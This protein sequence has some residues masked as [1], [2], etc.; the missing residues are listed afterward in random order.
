MDDRDRYARE[1]VDPADAM[2]AAELPLPEGQPRGFVP[3]RAQDDIDEPADEQ[4]PGGTTGS[5][6]RP[7]GDAGSGAD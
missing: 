4:T 2:G 7:E 6:G 3:P 1:D 5:A